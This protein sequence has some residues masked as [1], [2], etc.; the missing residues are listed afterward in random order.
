MFGPIGSGKTQLAAEYVRLH[1][2][3]YAVTWWVEAENADRARES[4]LRLARSLGVDDN[5][6]RRPI[7]RVFRLL[8]ESGPYLLVFDGVINGDVRTLIR[9]T[10]GSVIVTTR[11]GGWARESRHAELEVPDLDAGES[12]QLLRKQD[13]HITRAQ[14]ARLVGVVGRSPI[15]LAVACRLYREQGTSWDDLADRLATPDNR[16]L[17]AS[18]AAWR[19]RSARSPAG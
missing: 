6:D 2:D 8:E 7:D 17:T 14:T 5:D 11:N 10:G 19:R 16:M 9:T 1:R 12:A 4:L 15:G 13:P 3:R 18:P